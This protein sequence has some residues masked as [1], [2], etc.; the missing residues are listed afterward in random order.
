MY[1][2]ES[3]QLVSL[4][5]HERTC[6]P[7]AQQDSDSAST[8]NSRQCEAMSESANDRLLATNN[9]RLDGH[10]ERCEHPL[11]GM[12]NSSDDTATVATKPGFH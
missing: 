5:G 9:T 1:I 4:H 3:A 10:S 8:A 7:L 11:Y 2:L 12:S 6:S